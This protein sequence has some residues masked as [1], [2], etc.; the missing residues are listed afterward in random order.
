MIS[1]ATLVIKLSLVSI[2]FAVGP[3]MTIYNANSELNATFSITTKK[4]LS[5]LSHI[6]E[7]EFPLEDREYCATGL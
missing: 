4:S 2:A 6:T 5:S 3:S 1:F 7:L